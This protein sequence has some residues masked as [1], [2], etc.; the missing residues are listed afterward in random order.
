MRLLKYTLLVIGLT[1]TVTSCKKGFLDVPDKT[2]LIRQ[3]YVVDLK[4]T[5]EF[6]NG[7]YV[8]LARDFHSKAL[9]EIY[10]D[11]IADNIKPVNIASTVLSPQYNWLQVAGVSGSNMDDRW[12][13]GYQLIR[14]CSFVIEKA[15]EFRNQN[16]EKAD[17]MKAQ[18]LAMRAFIHS[19]LVSI[20]SQAFNFTANG[21]HPG[22][23]YVTVSDYTQPVTRNTV[24][25]VYN[26]MIQDLN[27]AIPLFGTGTVNPLFMNRNAAKGLLARVYLYKGDYLQAKNAAREVGT[28]VPIMTG[29]SYPSKLFT[30]EETE[31]LFQLP[32]VSNL[33]GGALYATNFQGAYY[34]NPKNFLATAD[35]GLLLSQRSTDVR[36]AW[37]TLNAG[38]WNITK[39]PVNLIPG[40]PNTSASYYQTL[41]R[42][43]EMYLTAAEAYAQLNNI[44]SA[45]FYLD[46]IRQRAD[47]TALPTTATGAALL[48]LIYEE[49]RKE[50]AFEGLR[51]YDLLRW[52]RAVNRVDALSPSVQQLP[53]PS[54]K[55]IAPIPVNDVNLAGFQQNFGY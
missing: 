52:K 45:R 30:T 37:V 44:D 47:V 27:N 26:G 4:S 35:I 32:P 42:S 34:V 28:R 48:E 36:K 38:N 33:V 43:S 11:L 53:Y 17:D 29:S 54:D 12:C 13:F 9:V 50:L 8:I 3:D 23:P 5:E 31:T 40:F 7:V 49:R 20:F 24:A 41:L 18:A 2:A 19:T 15:E 25:E 46:A 55:A 51:M 16:P 1:I 21:S 14:S 6:L 22:I 39:Y 10:P